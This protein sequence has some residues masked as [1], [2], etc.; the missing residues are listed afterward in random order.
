MH[1]SHNRYWYWGFVAAG[2]RLLVVTL[3]IGFFS[4]NQVLKEHTLYG[5]CST[6]I[7]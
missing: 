4:E 3:S 2:R 6:H 7:I 5:I 1:A